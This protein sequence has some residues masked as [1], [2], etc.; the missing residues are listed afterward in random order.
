[1]VWDGVG[2]GFGALVGDVI[3][4]VEAGAGADDDL[5]GAGPAAGAV[6]DVL[7]VGAGAELLFELLGLGRALRCLPSP[8]VVFGLALGVA[9]GLAPGLVDDVVDVGAA[10]AVD[11]EWLKR[12]M[13]PAMLAALSSVARQVR[14][15]TLRKPLS[16][17]APSR[18]RYLMAPHETGS[19]VKRP[20]RA[21]Q[22]AV[23]LPPHPSVGSSSGPALP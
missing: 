7:L 4:G 3:V 16:R 13:K 17:R 20:P 5:L 21:I 1:V 10:V 14:V 2:L 6:V 12:F 9:L 11:A 18:S 22:G 19:Y 15:D 8:W 23:R